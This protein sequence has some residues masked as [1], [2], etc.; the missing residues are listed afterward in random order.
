LEALFDPNISLHHQI[1]Q[2]MRTEILDGVWVGRDDFPG[3]EELAARYGVSV[4]TSRKSLVRLVEDGLVDRGRGRRPRATYEPRAT[5]S[6][7]GPTVFPI[8]P[9]RP[10]KYRIIETEIRVAQAEACEAFGLKYGVQLWHCSRMR[11][12]EGRPHSFVVNV[13]RPEVGKKHKAAKLATLPMSSI[14]QQEGFTL[15]N[16]KRRVVAKLPGT[17]AAQQLGIPMHAAIL[18]YTFVLTDESDAPIEWVQIA[19]HPNESPPLEVFDLRTGM[20]RV[21]DVL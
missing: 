14:L 17:L 10:Y 16:I 18:Y 1:Y 8:G 5:T 9:H 7:S 3:E 13:Q 15:G 6:S 4:I 11:H 12:F 2:Q 19:L 20:V 21:T